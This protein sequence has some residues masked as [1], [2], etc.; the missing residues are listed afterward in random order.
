MIFRGLLVIVIL[1]LAS[2]LVKD[3][4][5]QGWVDAQVRDQGPTG[6][7][8]FVLVSCLLGSV[9][10][11]RQLIAFL[12]G[13]AFGFLQGFVFSMLAVV[14]A[15]VTTFIIARSLL[16]SLLEK[17]FTLRIQQVDRF[18]HENTF[19]MAL[20]VRLL[21]LGSNWMINIAAGVSSVR[22]WPFFLGSALGYI[23][24]MLIFS[25]VGS[26]ARI[27]QFWQVAIAMALLVL[28][29]VLGLV[30]YRRAGHGRAPGQPPALSVARDS[31][32]VT[33]E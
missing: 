17:R 13:Y 28:A 21:P 26:G 19:T 9:G 3:L 27:D 14:A 1:V 16:R 32:G 6:V 33:Q 4:L 12:G 29:T 18:L 22:K 2:Y 5:D 30:L 15:C 25:L 8:L 24:Q 7:L 10:L 11:S 20:L 31:P 23:P